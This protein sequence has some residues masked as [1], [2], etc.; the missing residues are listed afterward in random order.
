MLCAIVFMLVEHLNA[1]LKFSLCMYT[2]RE[3]SVTSNPRGR[4]LLHSKLFQAM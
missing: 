4:R 3:D 1:V 2:N